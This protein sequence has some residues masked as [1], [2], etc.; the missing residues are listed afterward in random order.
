[1]AWCAAE[2]TAIIAAELGAA[3]T[4]TAAAEAAG[5]SGAQKAAAR[6]KVSGAAAGR[7]T[8][9]SAASQQPFPITLSYHL[10]GHSRGAKTSVL[11]V[12]SSMRP[13][14]SAVDSG[15]RGKV[16]SLTLLDPVDGSFEVAEGTAG[17]V[18]AIVALKQAAQQQ[19][20]RR[21]QLSSQDA[22]SDT[23]SIPPLLVIGAGKNSDCVPGRFNYSRFAEAAAGAAAAVVQVTLRDVG[24]LQFLDEQ[25]TLQRS[26]CAQGRVNEAAVRAACA[27]LAVAWI[28]S[29]A[30]AASAVSLP[31]RLAQTLLQ[32]L[33]SDTT[34]G[35]GGADNDTVSSDLQLR[36]RQ[37]IAIAAAAS[38]AG[39]AAA[40]ADKYSLRADVS[41]K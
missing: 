8:P 13:I 30:A 20:E 25:T 7:T 33:Q 37:D 10:V 6:P 2:A 32:T 17:F 21:R 12:L 38:A 4:I 31:T 39:S 9:V 22:D 41:V 14:P 34:S 11:A 35:P 27:E 24:H 29:F 28:S 3:A 16:A 5:R 36:R 40:V 23:T 19:Q 15:G 1:M 18:S 26:V